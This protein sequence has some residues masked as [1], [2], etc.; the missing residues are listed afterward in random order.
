MRTYELADDP[1][2]CRETF[3]PLMLALVKPAQRAEA[4]LAFR[5]LVHNPQVRLELVLWA[6]QS[7]PLW[8]DRASVATIR[9]GSRWWRP[10]QGE[11]DGRAYVGPPVIKIRSTR[12]SQLLSVRL[13]RETLDEEPE[14][15]R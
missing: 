3:V 15:Q 11:A 4:L 7:P 10:T 14:A 8:A 1:T 5:A 9:S 12:S 2:A 13:G 6:Y